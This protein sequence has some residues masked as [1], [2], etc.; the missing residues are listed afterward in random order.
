MKSSD[1]RTNSKYKSPYGCRT[2]SNCVENNG[3]SSCQKGETVKISSSC[4]LN[5]G[6]FK[7]QNDRNT[8][9]RLSFDDCI[10]CGQFEM[11]NI[12]RTSDREIYN[13]MENGRFEGWRKKVF[14]S[15][16]MSA[17]LKAELLHVDLLYERL[18]DLETSQH[19]FES[20]QNEEAF[21]FQAGEIKGLISDKNNEIRKSRNAIDSNIEEVKREICYLITRRKSLI[22]SEV[23]KLR[24]KQRTTKLNKVQQKKAM[25]GNAN[26]AYQLRRELRSYDKLADERERIYRKDLV[27]RKQNLRQKYK[28]NEVIVE[29][30][31]QRDNLHNFIN[32]SVDK[33]IKTLLDRSGGFLPICTKPCSSQK[34]LLDFK[35]QTEQALLTFI[36]K[37]T[38]QSRIT[39]PTHNFRG[40]GKKTSKRS[41]RSQ[42]LTNLSYPNLSKGNRQIIYNSLRLID[43]Y[44]V[45]AIKVQRSVFSVG[46]CWGRDNLVLENLKLFSKKSDCILRESDKKLGWS[47]SSLGWY[48]KEYKRQLKTDFYSWVGDV[49][50]EK[51][52]KQ[53]SSQGPASW[54]QMV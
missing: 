52:V 39:T 53:K 44:K 34:L 31:R 25:R 10:S 49:S 14:M 18:A 32:T 15:R 51:E 23:T 6:K 40:T 42:I 2:N 4:C 33:D 30:Q 45:R 17:L 38:G 21:S 11:N 12:K 1:S 16:P 9:N 46:K 54:C 50:K 13:A 48:E 47:L 37:V 22:Y 27:A 43:R 26:N 19:K 29:K 3:K 8:T 41:V 36:C 28:A 24:Q 20:G 35:R 5:P 7:I